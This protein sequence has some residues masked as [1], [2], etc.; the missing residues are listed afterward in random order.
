MEAIDQKA[1]QIW[2]VMSLCMQRGFDTEG[3]LDG[4]LGSHVE[5]PLF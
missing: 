5:H 3:I 4:G 1:D 2:K